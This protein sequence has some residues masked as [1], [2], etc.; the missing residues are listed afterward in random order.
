MREVCDDDSILV[1]QNILHLS[2]IFASQLQVG[3]GKNY[4]GLV[5]IIV[6]VTAWGSA[7]SRS[8]IYFCPIFLY[9][10][11]SRLPSDP[12]DSSKY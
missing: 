3:F 11:L 5:E 4:N 10:Q 1:D 12:A 8:W 9:P 7:I 6:I 2:T